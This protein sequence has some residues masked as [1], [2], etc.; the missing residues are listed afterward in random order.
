MP[1]FFRPIGGFHHQ[2]AVAAIKIDDD[3]SSHE[4]LTDG[5]ERFSG[6]VNHH[7][8][9]IATWTLVELERFV[10]SEKW[11]EIDDPTP[12]KSEPAKAV[13]PEPSEFNPP[14]PAERVAH[15]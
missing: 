12:K 10:K 14:E 9:A 5:S 4:V 11:E 7:Q 13:E 3:G 1:R 2:P 8:H 6:S 15:T